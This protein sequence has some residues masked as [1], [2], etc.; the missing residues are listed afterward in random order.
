MF[1]S[2]ANLLLRICCNLQ[3]MQCAAIEKQII[4]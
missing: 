2:N 1:N 4:I 3:A